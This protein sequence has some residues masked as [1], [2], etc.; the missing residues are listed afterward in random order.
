[1][2]PYVISENSESTVLAEY[3]PAKTKRPTSYQSEAELEAE[4][5][6]LLVEQGYA[7]LKIKSEAEFIANLRER[8]EEL[9]NYQFSDDEW[10]RFFNTEI[11][12]NKDIGIEGKTQIIQT[13]CVRVLKTDDKRSK[14]IALIDKD[15]IHH[16][17]VQV[18]NQYEE[19]AGTHKS[20]YDVTILVNGLPLVHVELKRRGVAIKEAFNQIE[21]YQRESFW[22]GNGLF[23]YVQIFIISNGTETKYY[24]NTTRH[25]HIQDFEKKQAAR[26]NKTSNSFEFTSYWADA[27]NKIIPDLVDFAKT[28][29]SKHTLLNI[30]TKYCVFTSERMLLVM[31]PYQIAATEQ[32]LGRIATSKNYKTYGSIKGGGYVWH[33]TGSGKTLTSFKTAQLASKFDFIDKVL[34]VVDRKDLDYQTMREY[35]RFEKGAA[36][37]N[38]STKILE[39]QLSDPNAKIIVTTIQ[40]LSIFVSRNK[41]HEVFNKRVVII[42]D[43]CHRSQFGDMHKAVVKAFKKYNLFGVTG[44]PIF[45]ENAVNKNVVAKTTEQ[46]FGDS[47]HVYTIVDAVRDK[48]VLPFRVDYIR[49]MKDVAETEDRKVCGIDRESAF[50]APKRI[51]KIAK[52]IFENFNKKTYRNEFGKSY[53]FSV[54]KDVAKIASAR[55][56][57]RVEEQREKMRLSGFNSIF[58]VAS[59]EAAKKYYDEFS[60]LAKKSPEH[61]L[62]IATIFSYAANEDEQNDGILGE[63][64]SEDT[65]QLDRSSR[66]FLDR[67]IADYNAMFSANYST[68][69]DGFQNYYRDVS[70]R[71]K[72]REID[73]LI[74]VNMFLTGFDATTVNTL[75]VDKNLRQHGLIQA[76]SRTNR[77]LNSIKTFGNIVCFR[78]L[79]DETN[80]AIAL[81]GDSEANGI[82]ILRKFKD[83]YYGYTDEN[84]EH[85]KGYVEI[86]ESLQK[87]FPVEKSIVTNKDKKDFIE[88]FGDFLRR[89]N[90][91]RAFDEFAGKEILTERDRQDYQSKYN[92]IY[93][94]WKGNGGN[95]VQENIANDINF[96]IELLKQID[97]DIDY[98]L[99]LVEKYKKKR[100]ASEKKEAEKLR[101]EIFRAIDSSLELRSKR[102]LIKE[103]I[104]QEGAIP[105]EEFVPLKKK[106][107][108]E[109]IIEKENLK[110]EKTREF[111]DAAFRSGELRETGTEFAELLP[112]MS[113]FSANA[114]IDRE[115]KKARVFVALKKF[116]DMF[117]GLI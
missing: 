89:Q 93:L 65:S 88:A 75:W 60:R 99:E 117:Y 45:S 26:K 90:L 95:N 22:A 35:D 29:C 48:N 62:K 71:M 109:K 85:Q 53:E 69:G 46:L 43:E 67:A 103:F 23:E 12:P 76:F 86:V 94:E 9:N 58:C 102:E 78:N 5:I 73:L 50:L 14:N 115:E 64:N 100:K 49:T 55:N 51:E 42:F 110:A 98:I 81:Y 84:G 87:K 77:I 18:L 25:G 4:F 36:N 97:I 101:T 57:R 83:Y 38:S 47:L 82:C 116:F 37:G 13:D 7:Y 113:R 11:A 52:Y 112:S 80:K 40:K 10:E 96:E 28:F 114:G 107:K 108:L 19:N 79:E 56:R 8:L 30:L 16:N 24:S 39:K 1:M 66:D 6:R 104:E 74:V 59:I 17:C 61:A 105:W 32:I 72:N 20:R 27:S 91:L 106:E 70:M 54:L 111:V 44:T 33:T 21:R 92:D 63:E 15:D 68:N 3:K 41:A 34:F 2:V 31:R